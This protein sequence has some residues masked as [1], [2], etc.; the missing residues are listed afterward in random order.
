MYT[1]K[2]NVS[3]SNIIETVILKNIAIIVELNKVYVKAIYLAIYPRAS[4]MSGNVYLVMFLEGKMAIRN[5]LWVCIAGFGCGIKQR[6][7]AEC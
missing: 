1:L 6:A 7:G 3:D 4:K 5:N 2:N